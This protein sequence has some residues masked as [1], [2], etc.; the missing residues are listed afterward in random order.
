MS[1]HED[2]DD[3]GL[4]KKGCLPAGVLLVGT[5]FIIF[6]SSLIGSA[7]E[8]AKLGWGVFFALMGLISVL[9]V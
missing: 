2:S 5:V 3:H 6:G 4:S 8:S 1:L 9:K 7:F